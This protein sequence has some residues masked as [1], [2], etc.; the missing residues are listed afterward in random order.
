MLLIIFFWL[1][2]GY[3][4]VTVSSVCSTK[5]C[6]EIPYGFRGPAKRVGVS[7]FSAPND[8]SNAVEGDR[9]KEQD[10]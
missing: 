1:D 5:S 7:F 9:H 10:S 8:P 6:E 4:P 3:H 2:P